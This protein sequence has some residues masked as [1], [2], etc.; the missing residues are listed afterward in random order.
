[1]TEA[2]LMEHAARTIAERAAIPKRIKISSSLPV[3]AVGKLFKPA[4]VEL[5]I[6]ETIRAEAER[7]GAAVIF[8]S[9]DRDPKE[10]LVR[11]S[12]PPPAPTR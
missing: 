12:Q 9:V 7:V 8:V 11:S 10:V 4:L 6:E 3:T 2:E 5:E 1:M